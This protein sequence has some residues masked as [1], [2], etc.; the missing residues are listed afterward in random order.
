MRSPSRARA[1]AVIRGPFLTPLSPARAVEKAAKI[2]HHGHAPKAAAPAAVEVAPTT[3][4]AAGEAT[5]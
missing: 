3:D 2:A 1:R 5:Q 4:Q